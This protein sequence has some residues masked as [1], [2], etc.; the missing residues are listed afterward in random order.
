M[1]FSY[2]RWRSDEIFYKIMAG[3]ALIFCGIFSYLL[4]IT[5]LRKPSEI[6]NG[7]LNYARIP[8]FL[9]QKYD[10]I[11]FRDI[12]T[13]ETE[14]MQN[15]IYYLGIIT[16]RG[17]KYKFTLITKNLPEFVDVLQKVIGEKRW[18]EIHR[19]IVR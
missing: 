2:G 13:I 7:H 1:I 5:A 4:F 6:Y 19:K 8:I 9:I 14:K 15:Q 12:S 11:P 17:K 16:K 18:D 3:I 10:S